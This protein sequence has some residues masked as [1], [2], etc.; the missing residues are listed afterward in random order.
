M[1]FYDSFL[2]AFETLAVNK[3][4]SL[5]TMLGILIGVV[6]VILLVSIGDGAKQYVS[7]QVSSLGSNILIVFAGKTQTHGSGPPILQSVNKM[8][9]EDSMAIVK[10][11]PSV[12]RVAPILVGNAAVRFE[13]RSRDTTVIGTTNEFQEVRNLRVEVGSYLPEASALSESRVCVLGRVV[14]RELF[15]DDNPL[16][17]LVTVGGTKYRVVGVM[18][19]KGRSLG[20]DLDDLVFIPVKSSQRLFNAEGL[21]EI[22]VSVV[23]SGELK[24]AQAQVIDVMKR[25]HDNQEDFTVV[26]QGDMLSVLNTMLTALTYALGGIAGISLLVGG[27]GI[28]NIL[29]V[30]VGERTREIGLRKAIGAKRRDILAQFLIESVVLASVG[31]LLGLALGVGTTFAAKAALPDLPLKLSMWTLATA[32]GVSFAVGVFFG[33]YPARR[34]SMLNPIEALRHE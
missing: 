15:G 28:M 3:V 27:I 8:T 34:A 14:K 11:C 12:K 17:R 7:D 1:N 29:L 20:L 26:D 5:L 32:V 16:G 18:R 9:I 25:R 24:R 31:G 30:S 21:L 2:L 13:N 10:E 33:V 22:I 19:R 23:N 6:S 4:R